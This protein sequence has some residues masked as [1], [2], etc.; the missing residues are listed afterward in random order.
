MI[1]P[2]DQIHDHVDKDVTVRGWMFNK[3]GSGK[4]HFLQLRDGTGLIQG[5]CVKGEVSDEVFEKGEKLTMESAVSVTGN[6][7]KHPKHD[8]VFREEMMNFITIISEN[9]KGKRIVPNV[10]NLNCPFASKSIKFEVSVTFL[11]TDV[12]STI[13]VS[14]VCGIIKLL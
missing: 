13:A 9:I 1:V 12:P 4:I 8:D 10:V 2:I 11:P 6:V 7:T 3:R 14:G 5:I